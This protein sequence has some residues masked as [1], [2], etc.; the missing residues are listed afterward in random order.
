MG[1]H[2][3]PEFFRE[4]DLWAHLGAPG[5]MAALSAILG[6]PRGDRMVPMET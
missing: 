6:F 5:S 4:S 1:F 3:T 2:N